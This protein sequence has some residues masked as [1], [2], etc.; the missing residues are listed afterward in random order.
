MGGT[1]PRMLGRLHISPA[2][3]Q[4][5]LDT[6]FDKGGAQ[7]VMEPSCVASPQYVSSPGGKAAYPAHML[8]METSKMHTYAS[9][10]VS[11]HVNGVT[12]KWHFPLFSHFI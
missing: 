6:G 2:V 11:T 3:A 10:D 12:K 5:V 8:I 7:C 9:R 1:G 4:V